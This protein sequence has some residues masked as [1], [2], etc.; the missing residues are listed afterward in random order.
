MHWANNLESLG[1]GKTL[2]VI[3]G[4]SCPSTLSRCG[5]PRRS[6]PFLAILLCQLAAGCIFNS[7]D[8][9]KDDEWATTIPHNLNRKTSEQKSFEGRLPHSLRGILDDRCLAGLQHVGRAQ[10]LLAIDFLVQALVLGLLLHLFDRALLLTVS[11]AVAFGAASHHRAAV[12]G[13]L[14]AVGAVG[15]GGGVL[16]FNH[17][18]VRRHLLELIDEPLALHFSQD[19]SLVVV[20]EQEQVRLFS[21][22]I[23]TTH[24]GERH[25]NMSR[26]QNTEC[27]R[28]CGSESSQNMENLHICRYKERKRKSPFSVMSKRAMMPLQG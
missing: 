17:H 20:P 5:Q 2:E 28:I 1:K 12:A 21:S 10:E 6:V 3:G 26:K 13:S 25:F 4:T 24:T 19:A 15:L 7:T 16:V 14:V 11:P 18:Q 23:L 8:S 27:H 9:F 22:G